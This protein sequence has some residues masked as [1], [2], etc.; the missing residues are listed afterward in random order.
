MLFID[1]NWYK[2]ILDHSIFLSQ[3]EKHRA[4]GSVKLMISSFANVFLREQGKED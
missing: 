3:M 4:N 1:A 2:L